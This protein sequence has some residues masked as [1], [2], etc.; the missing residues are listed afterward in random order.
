MIVRFDPHSRPLARRRLAAAGVSLR[1]RAARRCAFTLLEVVL[2]VAIAVGLLTV[3]LYFYRQAADL[4][5][6]LLAESERVS[7]IRLALDRLATDLRAALAR[8]DE[9]LEFQGD[10]VSMRFARAGLPT[11]AGWAGGQHGRA[12]FAETDLRW[13]GYSVSISTEGTNLV[14]A[15]LV[16]TEETCVETRRAAE[17]PAPSST[18]NRVVGGLAQDT[19]VTEV[20]ETRPG[21]PEPMSEAIRYVRFRYYGDSGW[22]ERWSGGSLPRGVEITLSAEL[23]EEVP[24]GEMPTQE[25]FRRVVYLP[26]TGGGA[27]SGSVLDDLSM[28]DLP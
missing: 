19:P 2:A 21:R 5:T 16:R 27:P 14:T 13:I 26:Q 9:G 24:E 12:T 7:A 22:V 11:F 3:V 18:V 23:V 25:I 6:Q 4:R 10:S 1:P 15:G 8:P 17:R 28:E 20:A